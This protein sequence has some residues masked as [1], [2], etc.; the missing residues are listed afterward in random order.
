MTAPLVEKASAKI[1]LTLRVLGRRADGYHLLESL[2]VFADVA[3]TLSLQ[4]GGDAALAISGPFAAAC[5]SV[6]GNLVLKAFAVA[7]ASACRGSRPGDFSLRR[8]FRSQPVSA[9]ARPMRRP[10]CGC[11]RA[12]TVCR[13]TT[14]GSTAAAPSVGADV[15]VCLAS[16]A[17]IMRGVGE[18]LSAPLD[19]PPLPA[20]LVNPG[21]TLATRD[22]FAAFAGR[23]GGNTP[24]GDVP[25]N[26][27]G[28]A[29]M[30]GRPR[31]RSDATGHRLCARYCRRAE[32][33][34]RSAGRPA[35]AH[36]GLGFDLLCIVCVRR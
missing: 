4:P 7:C 10:R 33:L 21:V 2:V 1:N 26:A 19:L 17:C 6:D 36:V 35:R 25:R 27:G 18:E 8:T 11:S 24:L 12:P 13:P 22:V 20:L 30:A 23:E 14:C 15:P 34:G 32:D 29:R 31:Q 9:A 28:L 5:G 3:D 16:R